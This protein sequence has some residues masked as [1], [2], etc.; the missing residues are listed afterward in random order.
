MTGKDASGRR[1]RAGK[2]KKH[3]SLLAGA[4]V[5]LGVCVAVRYFWGPESANAQAPAVHGGARRASHSVRV[6]TPQAQ[7]KSAP[8]VD[9]SQLKIMAVVNGE[10]IGR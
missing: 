10:Q 4:L 2:W 3:L 1:P 9:A 8:V 5:V 7:R 6:N